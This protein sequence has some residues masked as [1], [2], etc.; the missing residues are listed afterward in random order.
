MD[1]GRPIGM[2]FIIGADSMKNRMLKQE[3]ITNKRK[4]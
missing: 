4:P 2:P 1:S 3:R